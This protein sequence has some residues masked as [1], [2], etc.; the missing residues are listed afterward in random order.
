MKTAVK[1]VA[2]SRFDARLTQDQKDL[3]EKATSLTGRSLIEFMISSAQKEANK[4]IEKHNT[5]LA[6][7]KDQQIFFEALMKPAKANSNL[8]KAV[9]QFNQSL[10]KS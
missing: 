8:K 3:F 1:Q 4:L 10:F 2:K 6:S 5:I 9:V 7:R